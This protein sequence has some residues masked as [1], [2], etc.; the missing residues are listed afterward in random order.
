MKAFFLTSILLL[1]SVLYGQ[2]NYQLFYGNLHAHTWYSDG[3]GT[4]EDAYKMAQNAGLDFFAVTPHNHIAAENS[5]KERKDGILIATNHDLYNGTAALTFTRKY[6]EQ[7]SDVYT[8]TKIRNA[9]SVISAAKSVTSSNFRAFYGQEFSTISSSNHINVFN[10]DSVITLKN[11]NIRAL[12]ELIHSSDK[13]DQIFLQLNHPNYRSDL[14]ICDYD[15][16]RTGKCKNCFND[17]GID[18]DDFG[19]FFNNWVKELDPYTHLIEVLSGPAMKKTPIANYHYK[20][21]GEDS[22]FFYL[23]QGLHISP[24]VGQDNHYETWGEM[25]DARIGIYARSLDMKDMLEAIKAN[26]T[27]ASEDK[28]LAIDFTINDTFMGSNINLATD[29]ALEIKVTV[30]DADEPNSKYTIELIHGHISPED[31][32][33]IH[34][35]DVDSEVVDRR[36]DISAGTYLFNGFIATG[37]PE[38]YLLRCKQEDDDRCWTA[39]IWIN[40]PKQAENQKMYYWTASGSSKV[41]H[42]EGCKT[43]HAIKAENLRSGSTPPEGRQQHHCIS[44]GEYD[45]D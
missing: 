6:K 44:N 33:N 42:I 40:H 15:A 27:F 21:T 37:K 23:K 25:N 34:Y 19:P 35:V 8:S 31:S 11:G 22:Y 4:P 29:D 9:K 18:T 17:Y 5:A 26:R 32:R 43:I 7:G 36:S 12:M 24:S 10:Y 30:R 3:S 41:Y 45:E 16:P 28:N 13:H 1:S 39:P 14:L 2:D 38:F 20:E